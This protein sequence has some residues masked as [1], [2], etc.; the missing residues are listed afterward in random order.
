MHLQLLDALVGYLLLTGRFR[1]GEVHFYQDQC[2]PPPPH[3]PSH[4]YA[5]QWSELAERAFI[6]QKQTSWVTS[7]PLG[8]LLAGDCSSAS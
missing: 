6:Q 8:L 1:P 5:L 4:S 7:D 2:P 3:R